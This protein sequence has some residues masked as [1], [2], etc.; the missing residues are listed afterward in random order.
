MLLNLHMAYLSVW[1]II[2][3]IFSMSTFAVMKPQQKFQD[4][5]DQSKLMA[6]NR[7]SDLLDG[8]CVW[9]MPRNSQK[10][11]LI[12]VKNNFKGCKRKCESWT[13]KWDRKMTHMGLK[14]DICYCYDMAPEN[15]QIRPN[16][17]CTY[18]CPGEPTEQCGGNDRLSVMQLNWDGA[19]VSEKLWKLT[20]KITG[21]ALPQNSPEKCKLECSKG[22]RNTYV[23][24]R[25]DICH[26]LSTSPPYKSMVWTSYCK[27]TCPGDPKHFCG[28]SK[29]GDEHYNIHKL[30]PPE[31]KS[32]FFLDTF[33]FP[34]L[35]SAIQHALGS[36]MWTIGWAI[37][38]NHFLPEEEAEAIKGLC[39]DAKFVENIPHI[40]KSHDLN[41]NSKEVCQKHCTTAMYAALLGSLCYCKTDAPEQ[42][43]PP[44]AS[45]DNCDA[46]NPVCVV[47]PQ[48]K[49][50]NWESKC[51]PVSYV[52]NQDNKDFNENAVQPCKVECGDKK[53]IGLK[54]TICHCFDEP[55]PLEDLILHLKPDQD[56]QKC[57]AKT[58]DKCGGPNR[59]SIY[60]DG[61]KDENKVHNVVWDHT[62][63][64]VHVLQNTWNW[65]WNT[66]ASLL[67][68]GVKFLLAGRGRTLAL[69]DDGKLIED[70]L[71]MIKTFQNKTKAE[72]VARL[73]EILFQV[74]DQYGK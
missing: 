72:G 48:E 68:N 71:Q 33:V 30:E 74:L 21:P 43:I 6:T 9:R 15:D 18:N 50:N 46:T 38:K 65:F 34:T 10:A 40:T 36:L 63:L 39:I 7:H 29:Q 58:D 24:L 66:V 53:V 20:N 27:D 22:E 37:Q 4:Q 5:S 60:R 8:G 44:A 56:C 49:Q 45:C 62:N 17:E 55:P 23:A 12:L 51:L 73:D 69:L 64:W 28:S 35:E 42:N 19:C 52:E 61:F 70:T 25:N 2:L 67:F 16:S 47:S 32:T 3:P 59:V 57:P 11:A 14:K 31:E 41:K 26:C 54:E 1:N 13:S